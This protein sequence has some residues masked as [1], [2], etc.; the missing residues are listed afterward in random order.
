MTACFQNLIFAQGNTSI[1]IFIICCYQHDTLI[2]KAVDYM[3]YV[4]CMSVIFKVIGYFVDKPSNL[5]HFFK[6]RS[7][8][9]LEICCILNCTT[10]FLFPYSERLKI[11]GW[12]SFYSKLSEDA[13]FYFIIAHN[14]RFEYNKHT[15]IQWS[16]S[17]FTRISLFL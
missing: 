16:G 10:T 6:K 13:F 14:E 9:S 1:S 4:T 12:E 7:P 3:L 15:T 2:K 17:I 5:I 11:V 8:S